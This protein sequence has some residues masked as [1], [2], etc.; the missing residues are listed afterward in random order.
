MSQTLL[1]IEDGCVAMRPKNICVIGASGTIGS[2][3]TKLLSKRYPDASL[4]PF[5]RNSHYDIDYSDENSIATAAKVASKDRAL[6]LVFVASGVLHSDY[7]MPEKSLKQLSAN[8][9]HYLF[10]ANTITPALIAKYFLPLLNKDRI[11][12]FAV[13]S[14]RVGSISDNYLGG[15]YSYRASKAALNM[16]IKNAAIEIRRTNKRA[17]VS[18]LHP[19]TVDSFLSRPFQSNVPKEKLFTAEYSA[20]K[21]LDV[22]EDLSPEQSGKC[23]AWDGFEVNP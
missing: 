4:F 8:K 21:L 5:S 14:A 7:I 10:Q 22:L 19:G 23:F 18:T 2:A 16:I 11:S 17:I 3:M 20:R 6:D 13:L 1:I 15:W 12:R 9:F